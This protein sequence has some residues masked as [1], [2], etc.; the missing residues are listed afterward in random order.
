MQKTYWWRAGVVVS[1]LVVL[2][3]AYVGPCEYSLGRCLGGNSIFVTR[4]FFH[5]ALSFLL[6]SPVLFL[7]NDSIFKKWFR[8]SI[9]WFLVA[10]VFILLV[11]EYQGG[12]LGIGP[13]KESVSI[14]MGMLFV[15]LSFGQLAWASWKTHKTEGLS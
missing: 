7:V 10:T 5:F 8:F 6:V 15:M 2:L 13:E 11:P 14:L 12:W 9:I 1:C 4:T 3:G